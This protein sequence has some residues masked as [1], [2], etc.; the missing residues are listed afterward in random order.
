M[1]ATAAIPVYSLFGPDQSI[2]IDVRPAP[3]TLAFSCLR[4][5]TR[6]RFTAADIDRSTPTTRGCVDTITSSDQCECPWIS[7]IAT[8]V[9]VDADPPQFQVI[10]RQAELV[11]PAAYGCSQSPS[12]I[13]VNLTSSCLCHSS[14]CAGIQGSS[15]APCQSDTAAS[16]ALPSKPRAGAASVVQFHSCGGCGRR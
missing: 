6:C 10:S 2:A 11:P 16:A 14:F 3:P 1:D 13:R 9:N 15:G 12:R 7:P 5:R 8:Y 4:A